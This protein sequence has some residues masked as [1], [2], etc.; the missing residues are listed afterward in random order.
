MLA[1]AL[2]KKRIDIITRGQ[3]QFDTDTYFRLAIFWETNWRPD[4]PIMSAQRYFPKKTA[5]FTGKLLIVSDSAHNIRIEIMYR[6][7]CLSA[8]PNTT[9]AE[10]ARSE[11]ICLSPYLPVGCVPVFSYLLSFGRKNFLNA[12]LIDE[13]FTTQV[14]EVSAFFVICQVRADAADQHRHK[15]PI[16]HVQPVGAANEFI[17]GISDEGTVEIDR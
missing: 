8:R 4:G 7:P 1:G 10:S 12:H 14:R 6:F 2:H 9:F 5:T 15:T 3:V 16:A 11:L 17:R 13:V